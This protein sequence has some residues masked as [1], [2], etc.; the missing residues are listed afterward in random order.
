MVR[1]LILSLVAIAVFFSLSLNAAAAPIEAPA[2][3]HAYSTTSTSAYNP[4]TDCLPVFVAAVVGGFIGSLA[5]N[6]AYDALDGYN[7]Q[8]PALGPSAELMFDY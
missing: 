7:S 1:K 2:A 6:F 3:A 4:G 8:A 5:A